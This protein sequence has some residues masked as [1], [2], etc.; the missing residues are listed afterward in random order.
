MTGIV[1]GVDGSADAEEALRWAM[2]QARR[3]DCPLTVILAWDPK[4]CPPA[5]SATTATADAEKAGAG[6]AGEHETEAAAYHLMQTA[7]GRAARLS[8][9]TAMVEKVERRDAAEALLDASAEA[10]MLV[11]GLHGANRK[12]RLFAGSVTDICLHRARP[13][14]VVVR[15]GH[16]RPT[17]PVV[18]G[19]DGSAASVAA[20][21]VAASQA[22]SR[23]TSLRVVHSWL[24]V[25]PLYPGAYAGLDLP[26]LKNAARALLDD[27]VAQAQ[28]ENTDLRVERVLVE[29][30]AAPGLLRMSTD[31]SLLVVGARGHGGFAELLLGSVSHQCVHHAGCPVAVVRA[32]D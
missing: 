29:D 20:L 5:V 18:V 6:T 32:A 17:G 28:E 23:E 9:P 2:A 11:L 7:I 19:V 31:A 30:A 4:H 16:L 26:T 25:A 27:C 12:H 3:Q 22:R 24:P 13:T 1:V 14:V 8:Q 15:S 21:R 10:E